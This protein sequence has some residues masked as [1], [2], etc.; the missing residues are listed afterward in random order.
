LATSAQTQARTNEIL[1][2]KTPVVAADFGRVF[3][4]KDTAMDCETSK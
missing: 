3:L 2:Q 4:P 1:I